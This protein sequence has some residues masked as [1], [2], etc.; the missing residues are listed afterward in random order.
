MLHGVVRVRVGSEQSVMLW[1]ELSKQIPSLPLPTS[2]R[3][4]LPEIFCC[5]STQIFRRNTQQLRFILVPTAQV[6][7]MIV[8]SGTSD[9][10]LAVVPLEQCLQ[11]PLPHRREEYHWDLESRNPQF[12]HFNYSKFH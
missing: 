7:M 12:M 9:Q 2:L 10:D 4:E 3:L 6:P 8:C 5:R 1:N 11:R